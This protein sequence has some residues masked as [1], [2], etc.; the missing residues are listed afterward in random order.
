MRSV[1]SVWPPVSRSAA[2]LNTTASTLSPPP[3]GWSCSSPPLFISL[4]LPPASFSSLTASLLNFH[5]CSAF[6]WHTNVS[7]PSCFPFLHSSFLVYSLAI[8]LLL[9]FFLSSRSQKHVKTT[10]QAQDEYSM[11]FCYGS[12]TATGILFL[13]SLVFLCLPVTYSPSRWRNA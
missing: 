12:I 4:Y 6:F 9:L 11:V 10:P 5:D 3:L 13:S 8:W 7:P 2:H 1:F